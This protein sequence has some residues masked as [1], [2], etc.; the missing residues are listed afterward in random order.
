MTP[1]SRSWGAIMDCRKFMITPRSVITPHHGIIPQTCGMGGDTITW[2]VLPE[3]GAIVEIYRCNMLKLSHKIYRRKK[4]LAEEGRRW[5]ANL[6]DH[7]RD[8][9]K[10]QVTQR[11]E[12]TQHVTAFL[13]FSSSSGSEASDNEK[14]GDTDNKRNEVDR[15]APNFDRLL[16]KQK[17]R[18]KKNAAPTDFYFGAGEANFKGGKR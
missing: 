3:W 2:G 15:M 17:K 14:V 9:V 6:N 12:N 8:D 18:K 1:H 5:L 10:K 16:S 7:Y 4:E 13:K 11:L